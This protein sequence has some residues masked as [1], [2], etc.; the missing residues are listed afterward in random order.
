ML[1]LKMFFSSPF[2]IPRVDQ[3]L[4][5]CATTTL[6]QLNKQHC[7]HLLVSQGSGDISTTSKPAFCSSGGWYSHCLQMVVEGLLKVESGSRPD[8]FFCLLFLKLASLQ[9]SF[10]VNLVKRFLFLLLLLLSD[11]ISPCF[12]TLSNVFLFFSFLYFIL[13]YFSNLGIMFT[14][15][16]FEHIFPKSKWYAKPKHH[17]LIHI[18]LSLMQVWHEKRPDIMDQWKANHSCIQLEK[19]ITYCDIIIPIVLNYGHVI[20]YVNDLCWSIRN[21]FCF[22]LA[23]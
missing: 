3:S 1:L 7:G 13:F 2:S 12:M 11:W 15:P 6:N 14:Q 19:L 17:Q 21:P 23:D 5:I 18:F 20:K 10:E 9:S 8:K 16:L 22:P 4:Q